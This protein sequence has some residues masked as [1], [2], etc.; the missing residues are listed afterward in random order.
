MLI[1]SSL[2]ALGVNTPDSVIRAE[3]KAGGCYKLV[4]THDQEIKR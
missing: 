1:N 3:T 4:M 2:T